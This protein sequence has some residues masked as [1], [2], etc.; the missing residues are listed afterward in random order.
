MPNTVRVQP[1]P[2]RPRF[3]SPVRLGTGRSTGVPGITFLR[4]RKITVTTEPAFR[5]QADGEAC[6][7]SPFTAEVLPG[8][9]T[10]LAPPAP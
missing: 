10:V 9:L 4:A 1:D 7:L 2:D 6:G 5:V 3:R 8:A